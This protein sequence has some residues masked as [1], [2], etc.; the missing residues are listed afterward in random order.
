MK[1]ALV[2]QGDREGSAVCIKL[3]HSYGAR[4][5]TGW[6]HTGSAED[7]DNPEKKSVLFASLPTTKFH[8]SNN[9][10]AEAFS[11]VVVALC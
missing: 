5:G 1:F 8:L 6:F 3:F 4:A 2:Q 7:L 10:T 9:Y 11:G